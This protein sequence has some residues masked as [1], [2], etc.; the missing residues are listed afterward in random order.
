M[1]RDT[2]GVTHHPPTPPVASA[3]VWFRRD[4]RTEDNAALYYALK[5]ARRVWCGFVFDRA[6]LDP[7]PRVDR[8]VEFIRDS[9]LDL[10]AQL[11]A[12]GLAHGVDGVGLIV[13]HGDAREALPALARELGVQAVYASHDDDPEALARDARVRGALAGAGIALHTMKDH[14]VFERSELLTATG[15][16]YSVFTPYKNA[17]LRK[18]DDF[19][20]RPYPV[21][22]HAHPLAPLPAALRQPPQVPTLGEIGFEPSNLHS[23]RL[24]TGSSGAQ[25]L[26]DDFLD[27]ID[28]YDRAR[29]FPAVK[30]PS[31]LSAHLRFGT[32]SVRRLAREAWARMLGPHPAGQ[33]GAEVW[34]SELI[35]RDFYHQILH[36]HPRVV[37]H[38]FKPEYDKLKW[39]HGKHADALFAAWCAGRTGYPLVDAAMLQLQRTG[40]MHNRLR[41]V[42]ASFLTKDLGLD[43]RRGEAWFA[44][45]LNDFDLAANNGG[46]QW[47]AST[48]CDAQPY[49]RIFN[50]V[51]QSEK[52]DAEGK[53]IRR[54]LPQLA[55]LPDKLIHA[56]WQ[57][58]PLE[59]AA[60]GVTLD[61]DY[62]RPVVAHDLARERTL[63]R[64]ALVK[65]SA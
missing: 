37:G 24:P 50:P 49:F 19:Y 6:I 56:P 45:H 63:A 33:R 9:L 29:D 3:L 8:R 58:R 60:A 25:T 38:C 17:W 46:W 23:L 51:S 54:Y 36:H 64:F 34:L 62:P 11:R 59:L 5:A 1:M 43:W 26:L 57:A 14:V 48:G 13:R 15:S 4:L 47:A 16:A 7:L 40:Y 18:V 2:G 28:D 53:F 32:V 22:R 27:R 42:V 44:T 61:E 35:W 21:A 55:R 12:L 10:D 31:Y 52:F 30:G 39:D 65:G 41:M 20:L